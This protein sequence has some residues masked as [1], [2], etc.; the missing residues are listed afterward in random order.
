MARP[1]GDNGRVLGHLGI[2][3]PDLR[4]AREYYGEILPLLDYEPFLSADDEFAYMPAGGTR[5]AYLFFYQAA[6]PGGYA[7]ESTGLQHL[8]FA[9]PTRTAVQAAHRRVVELGCTVLHHPQEFP[10]YPPPYYAT[11]WLDLFGFMLEA[12]CHH[13]RD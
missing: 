5:G 12:V 6:R 8:A 2:N 11:F 10:Q 3:V 9:V 13:D 7:R 4:Q 1:I